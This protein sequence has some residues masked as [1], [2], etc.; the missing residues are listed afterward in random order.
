MNVAQ[1]KLK[2]STGSSCRKADL[3][4]RLK[5]FC[6]LRQLG[7]V[8]TAAFALSLSSGFLF[9]ASLAASSAKQPKNNL[10]KLEYKYF[11]HTYSKED[12]EVR[13]DRLEKMVFGEGKEGAHKERLAK[14]IELVPDLDEAQ[15]ESSTS[16]SFQSQTTAKQ[17]AE[18]EERADAGT[19]YPAVSAIEQK[20]FGKEFVDD[21][22]EAR[23]ARLE[24]RVFGK[25]ST[26]KDLSTRTDLLK[27]STG[28]DITK[29]S[30]SGADWGDDEED[31]DFPTPNEPVARGY[32]NLRTKAGEDGRSFSGRDLRKDFQQAFGSSYPGTQPKP[33]SSGAYSAQGSGSYGM[34]TGGGGTGSYGSGSY[35]MGSSLNQPPKLSYVPSAAP[36]FAPPPFAPDRSTNSGNSAGQASSTAPLAN[37]SMGLSQSVAGLE[38]AVF[39]KQYGSDP[40]SSRVDRLEKTIFPN[41]VV[42]AGADLKARV[43]RIL[44]MIPVGGQ[45]N[46]AQ[47]EPPFESGLP[48][49]PAND[50]GPYDPNLASTQQRKSSISKILSSLGNFISGGFSVGAYPMTGGGLKTDPQTGLL[51]D[52]GSGNLI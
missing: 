43:D 40:L 5:K 14:L 29:N 33:F 20:L 21:K 42:M 15:A 48:L 8:I 23:L 47:Q 9:D 22:V 7:L 3:P 12:T 13:L 6:Q 11:H 2:L 41:Q 19:Q 34:S 35:G 44:G 39:G 51:L 24:S 28:V 1:K 37:S 31:I 18:P 16:S 25:P 38:T 26:S 30:P 50:P 36:P 52:Q 46:I 27:Q 17:N 10:E 45:P 49:A 4:G 32:N